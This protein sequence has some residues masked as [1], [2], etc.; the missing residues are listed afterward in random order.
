MTI[1]TLLEALSDFPSNMELKVE[2]GIDHH[3]PIERIGEHHPEGAVGPNENY[4]LIIL[5]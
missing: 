3:V 1:E 5:E 4:L 2:F